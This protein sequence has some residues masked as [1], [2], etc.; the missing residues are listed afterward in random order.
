MYAAAAWLVEAVSLQAG[1]EG[2][3]AT[4]A[5]LVLQ[6]FTLAFLGRLGGDALYVRAIYTPI[7]F[8]VLAVTEGL[9]VAAQVSAGI[10]TRSGR[11]DTLRPLPTFLALGGGALILI[12]GVFAVA[13][14]AIMGVL[15]VDPADH[16][17]VLN[18]VVAV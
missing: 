7:S 9:V 11:R 18:F 14:E 2:V 6:I 8:L 3:L 5:G 4:V 15:E 17:E 1:P 13:S 16:G 12:A 10:A